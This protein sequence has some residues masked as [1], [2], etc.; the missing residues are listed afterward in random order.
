MRKGGPFV[1]SLRR[2]LDESSM[3]YGRRRKAAEVSDFRVVEGRRFKSAE[4]SMCRARR[5]RR[6]WYGFSHPLLTSRRGR[7]AS[8][9]GWAWLTWG[10]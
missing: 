8:R 9:G 3:F 2:S 10:F 6:I 1:V 7:R 4:E 5:Q